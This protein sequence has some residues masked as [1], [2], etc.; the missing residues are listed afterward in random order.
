MKQLHYNEVN[1]ITPKQI[2]KNISQSNLSHEGRPDIRELQL[3][4]PGANNTGNV[5]ADPIIKQMT[6]PQMEKLIAET[7][8]K[9]KEA[10]KQLDFLQ[11][12]QYRDE[13]IALQNE[14]ELK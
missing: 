7:T 4:T 5:A 3:S 12:A 9:M 10:A 8:R 13:I 2:V 14:L 11:A 6:R 1:H